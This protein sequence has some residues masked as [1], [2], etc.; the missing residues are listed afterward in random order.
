[1][2]VKYP[3]RKD[4]EELADIV[5]PEYCRLHELNYGRPTSLPFPGTMI[6]GMGCTTNKETAEQ[7]FTVL[8][9]S[10]GELQEHEKEEITKYLTKHTPLLHNGKQYNISICFVG[11]PEKYLRNISLFQL[12]LHSLF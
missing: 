10:E 12:S 1:M 2:P 6:V 5:F 11:T 3:T 8:V 7:E 4:I 9:S